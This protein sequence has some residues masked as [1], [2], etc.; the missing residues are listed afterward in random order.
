MNSKSAKPILYDETNLIW[1][2]SGGLLRMHKTKLVPLHLIDMVNGT[3]MDLTVQR[4]VYC[5]RARKST[6]KLTKITE[7][8]KVSVR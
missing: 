4:C 8:S 5:I 1:A 7:S 3:V 6:R 2:D